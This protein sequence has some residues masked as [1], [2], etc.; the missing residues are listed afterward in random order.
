MDKNQRL[1]SIYK[2]YV[3]GNNVNGAYIISQA[4]E[5]ACKR[6]GFKKGA[7]REGAHYR[8]GVFSK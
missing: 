1:L 6:A 5:E 3:T 2:R 4:T 7:K 8:G